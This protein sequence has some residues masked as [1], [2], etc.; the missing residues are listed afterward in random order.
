[1][2]NPKTISN[3]KFQVAAKYVDNALEPVIKKIVDKAN[4]ELAKQGIRL[5]ASINWMFDEV[6]PVTAAKK[7]DEDG[8]ED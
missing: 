2:N 5:G 1:M 7:V 8:L 4:E 3:A 6:E